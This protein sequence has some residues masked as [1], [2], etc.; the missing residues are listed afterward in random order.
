MGKSAAAL[1]L[2]SMG[3]PV[4]DSD[5]AVHA[6]MAPGG[7]AVDPVLA[8]FPGTGSRAGGIDRK[9]LGQKV[10]NDPEALEALEKILHPLVRE[11]QDRFLEEHRRKGEPLVVLEIPLLFETGADRRVDAVMVVT[12]PRHIQEKRVLSRPGMTREKF[13]W[14]LS[15]QMP[16]TEKRRRADIILQTGQG[17]A[18]VWHTLRAIVRDLDRGVSGSMPAGLLSAGSRPGSGGRQG[19]HPPAGE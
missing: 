12:A 18:R 9:A 2:R 1:M 15:H 13:S 14:I 6:L 10:F 4:H 16:D 5:A 11:R 7:E 19:R 17:R 3:I 8:R